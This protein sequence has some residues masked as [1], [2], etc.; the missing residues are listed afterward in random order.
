MV[1]PNVD[2]S[3]LLPGVFS[4]CH[5]EGRSVAV[6]WAFL[7][8]LGRTVSEKHLALLV[9]ELLGPCCARY[10]PD[11]LVIGLG[12]KQ[13]EPVLRTWSVDRRGL[14]A[15]QKW[16]PLR[17]NKKGH[18]CLTEPHAEPSHPTGWN[19]GFWAAASRGRGIPEKP[20]RGGW[21]CCSFNREKSLMSN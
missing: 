2:C 7:S 10:H 20:S 12:A 19:G 21:V 15:V 1:L 13:K 16:T 17:K 11:E 14:A 4:K 5:S 18:T 3:K 9:W 8:I 6:S